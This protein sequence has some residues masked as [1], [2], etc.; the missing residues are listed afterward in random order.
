MSDP[1]KLWETPDA[2]QAV[3]SLG[4][5]GHPL[6]QSLDPDSVEGIQRLLRAWKLTR[7]LVFPVGCLMSQLEAELAAVPWARLHNLSDGNAWTV[8]LLFRATALRAGV[9]NP[10]STLARQLQGL[11]HRPELSQLFHL[12]RSVLQT[13]AELPMGVLPALKGQPGENPELEIARIRRDLSTCFP[14]AEANFNSGS[15]EL[16]TPELVRQLQPL[17]RIIL[18]DH[19]S[20]RHEL[21]Q[22]LKR[23]TGLLQWPTSESVD[24]ASQEQQRLLGQFVSLS[25]RWWQHCQVAS[26]PPYALSVLQELN[27]EFDSRLPLIEQELQHLTDSCKTD[28]LQLSI[29][30]LRESLSQLRQLLDPEAPYPLHE[31]VP[32]VL[33]EHPDSPDAVETHLPGPVSSLPA[34]TAAESRMTLAESLATTAALPKLAQAASQLPPADISILT[35]L[36][37]KLR[38]WAFGQIPVAE[39]EE[40]RRLEFLRSPPNSAVLAPVP[41]KPD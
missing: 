40:L 18:N 4:P 33:F 30:C 19:R 11:T 14:S 37:E 13:F 2:S 9:L 38:P 32:A 41:G 16:L 39:A 26:M 31:P 27:R 8:E 17:V 10:H 35:H 12:S 23:L 7:S 15:A 28:W 36:R 5:P 34:V 25:H 6:S 3:A 1:A 21:L 29:N 20:A 22:G 24:P